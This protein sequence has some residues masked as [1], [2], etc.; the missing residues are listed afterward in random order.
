M[1]TRCIWPKYIDYREWFD[2]VAGNTKNLDA[3]PKGTGCR[4]LV[5]IEGERGDLVAKEW[6][7]KKPAESKL[8]EIEHVICLG[9]RK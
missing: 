3:L 4:F 9:V 6:K 5:V 2:I 1:R 8:S 7:R